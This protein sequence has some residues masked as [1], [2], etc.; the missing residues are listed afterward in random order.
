[1]TEFPNVKFLFLETNL[2]FAHGNNAAVRVA[3]GDILFILNPDTAVAAGCI[4]ILLA[5]LATHPDTG[6][7]APRLQ[8]E[9]G[10][11]QFSYNDPLTLWWELAEAFYFQ[12][13]LRMRTYKRDLGKIQR[14]EPFTVGWVSGAAMLIPRHIYKAVG[15]FD[16]DF[17][18]MYEDIGLCD[19]VRNLGYRIAIVPAATVIHQDGGIIAKNLTRLITNR[20]RARLVYVRKQYSWPAQAATRLIHIIGLCVRILLSGFLYRGRIRS[21]RLAGYTQ[22]LAVYLG[23]SKFD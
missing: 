10:R 1:P 18:L 6:I 12:D 21:E 13:V 11:P 7:A 16:E 4:S 15:G 19:R 17:F 23:L 2:G 5:Y 20:Y 9:D 22:S 14:G 3:S 8:Y